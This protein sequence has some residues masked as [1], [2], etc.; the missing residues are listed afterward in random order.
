[1]G[2][3]GVAVMGEGVSVSM[4]AGV[5]ADAG[6]DVRVR[7]A[8]DSAISSGNTATLRLP[9]AVNTVLRTVLLLRRIP[10]K[11]TISKSSAATTHAPERRLLR[12]RLE[13]AAYGAAV[14]LVSFLACPDH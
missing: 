14:A 8:S 7:M 10:M 1:M 3:V 11:A 12:R 5:S 4:S 9:N 6:A 2:P 13:T